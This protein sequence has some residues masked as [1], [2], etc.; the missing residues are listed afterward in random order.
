M[1]RSNPDGHRIFGSMG[2]IRSSMLLYLLRILSYYLLSCIRLTA[3]L[4]H[5][6]RRAS[7]VTAASPTS[8][9]TMKGTIKAMRS[10]DAVGR[11]TTVD[12][13]RLLEHA[14]LCGRHSRKLKQGLN[15]KSKC[16][17]KMFKERSLSRILPLLPYRFRVIDK[18]LYQHH[19]RH[20]PWCQHRF[21]I[22]ADRPACFQS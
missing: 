16:R 12:V 13:H 2:C 4:N 15:P 3:M 21:Q 1:G 9:R 7:H 20:Q 10:L 14:P 8:L 6:V 18:M 11:L 19:L 17:L 5:G 22:L